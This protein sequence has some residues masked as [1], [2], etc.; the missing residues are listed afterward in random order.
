MQ[1]VSEDGK[2]V[3]AKMTGAEIEARMRF[4]QSKGMWVEGIE[5]QRGLLKQARHFQNLKAQ[6]QVSFS[7]LPD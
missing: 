4:Y 1:E 7:L 3:A 2:Q 6:K 5:M